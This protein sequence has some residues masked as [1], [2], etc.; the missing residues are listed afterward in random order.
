MWGIVVSV[1]A[2]TGWWVRTYQVVINQYLQLLIIFLLVVGSLVL[3]RSFTPHLAQIRPIE[4]ADE[5]AF[6]LY[7]A[8]RASGASDA[9]NEGT[10]S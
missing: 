9:S 10:P 4:S 1:V 6:P 3:R 2:I 7:S 8:F 5:I